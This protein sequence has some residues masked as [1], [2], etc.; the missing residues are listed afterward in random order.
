MS[1]VTAPVSARITYNEATLEMSKPPEGGAGGGGGEGGG[2]GW[3][4]WRG[5]RTMQRQRSALVVG[6]HVILIGLKIACTFYL[7]E[8]VV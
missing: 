6:M 4:E 8:R 1:V 7:Y 5:R 2:G 3:G